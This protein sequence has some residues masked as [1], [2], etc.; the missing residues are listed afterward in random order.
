MVALLKVKK[1]I[2]LESQWKKSS[3]T[4]IKVNIKIKK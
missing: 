1:L 4:A 3:I 2:N